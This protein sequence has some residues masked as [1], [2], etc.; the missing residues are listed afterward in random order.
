MTLDIDPPL[1]LQAYREAEKRILFLD[2]D[3]TLVAFN[4]RPSESVM[5]DRTRKIIQNLLNDV[6]NNVY[7]ISGRDRQFLDNQF[8]NMRIG[9]IAEHGFQVKEPFSKWVQTTSI[10]TR[11]KEDVL[12]VLQEAS[13]HYPGTFVE[14]KESAV[15]FHYRTALNVMSKKIR[16]HL[17][18]EFL[19]IVIKHPG[20]VMM[21]GDKVIEIKPELFNKGSV[22]DRILSKGK[23]DFILAAG[24]DYTDELL[25]A[26]LP[27]DAFTIKIGKQPTRARFL[28]RKQEEFLKFLEQ[29]AEKGSQSTFI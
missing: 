19:S 21:G 22:A 6:K 16:D 20:I 13:D 29:V 23:H 25:F 24:D 11:W 3:G 27:N 17:K 12:A 26:R 14:E 18:M 28:I 15:V 9:L 5:V 2:Y 1:I 8:T 4:D 10:D 7:I